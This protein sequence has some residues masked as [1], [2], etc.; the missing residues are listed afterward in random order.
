L[1][2]EESI[3]VPLIVRDPRG[4]AELRGTTPSQ[5]ALNVD[6]APTILSLAGLQVPPEMQGV[7][8][9]PVFSGRA[10]PGRS[11]FY[12][13]HLF[14]HPRIPKSEGV[15][16]GRWSY[17]RYFE[18]EPVFEMLYDRVADPGQILNLAGEP[19]R[20]AVLERLRARCDE[21][22]DRLGESGREARR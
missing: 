21:L 7:S 1:I 20:R 17:A 15:R 18:Q 14:D 5:I 12:F 10:P 3:R 8:L 13:E 4:P 19:A 22:R 11:D 6:L 2:Y 16:D 9:V